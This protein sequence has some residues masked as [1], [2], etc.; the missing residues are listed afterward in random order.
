MTKA[1]IWLM[2]LGGVLALAAAEIPAA[3]PKTEKDFPQ[4]ASLWIKADTAVKSDFRK[5]RVEDSFSGTILRKL[6]KQ[7]E[8]GEF[9]AEYEFDVA[10]GGQYT[11]FAAL[12]AQKRPHASPVEFRF[13][14]GDWREV[15]N[16]P[17]SPAWGISNAI[18]WSS[19]GTV[20]LTAGKH[21]LALRI[22]KRAQLGS[23]SFM[24][25]GIVAFQNGVWKSAQITPPS[26]PATAMAGRKLELSYTQ[27]G[28]A[29]PALLRL[30]YAG[31]TVTQLTVLSRPGD[32]ANVLTLPDFLSSGQYQG[33]LVPADEPTH[34]FFALPVTIPAAAS[35]AARPAQLTAAVFEGGQYHLTFAG[36]RTS[37]VL[38]MFFTG[39]KL[40]FIQKL[41]RSTGTLPAELTQKLAGR[42][43][44]IRFQP[45][46]ADNDNF[47][48]EK[49]R[50]DGKAQSLPKPINYG[51]FT[52]RD[53]ITHVW[54][55]NHDF[56][57]IFDGVRYFP[58]GGM[59]CS[60]TLFSRSTD[61]AQI[62]VNLQKDLSTIRAIKAGGLDDV[63]LNLATQA[64]LWVRQAFVDMLQNEGIYYGYQLN[65][66]GG[67]QIPSF[68]ITRDRDDAPAN[69]RGLTR[70]TYANGKITARFPKEQKLL[71][72]LLVD[73]ATPQTS[74]RF[75][76]FADREGKDTRHGIIDLETQQDFGKLREISFAAQLALPD[77]TQVILIPLIEANMHHG[78]LWDETEMAELK[79]SLA[80]VG[81][82]NWGSNLRFWIEPIR[83]ET[84]MVNATENLR[85]Y[86]PAINRAFAAYLRERYQTLTKL[87]TAWGLA[88]NSF[89]QAARLIPLRLKDNVYYLDPEDGQTFAGSE[90]TTLAWIDYQ[91]MIRITYA[92]LADQVAMYLK[93]MVNVPVIFKSVGVIGEKLSVS[94]QYLGYDGVGFET[95]LNQGIPGETGGGASRAEAEASSHTMWKV[96]T[97]VGHSAAVGNGETKFFKDEAEIRGMADA[98]SRLGVRGFYF[99]GF[100]LKPGNLWL[101]HNYHDFPEGL[102]WAS[103]IDRESNAR[104][105]VAATPANYVFPGGF[106]W[107]WWTTRYHAVNDHEQNLIP[108]SA[109]LGKES[110]IYYSST[111][112]LPEQFNAVIINCPYPPFSRYHAADIEQAIRSGQTVY[113][114][115][116]RTD[117]GAIPALDA[118]FT[119][120]I[121]A[122]DDDSQAQVLNALPGCKILAAQNGKVWALAKDNLIIVSRTPVAKP[123]NSA[124][125]FLQYLTMF[126][127]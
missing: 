34:P 9:T 5:E 20:E 6:D 94:N 83:N 61:P 62:A 43:F 55:M 36:N 85:Q 27:S 60:D 19:L 75:F 127:R 39:G 4:K 117:L 77:Q 93:S 98:L 124:D 30:T 71:G 21:K 22:T 3:T 58:T 69:Y 88:V 97:E 108:Q 109:R 86:T 99:F 65:G 82:I 106:T 90:K 118:F 56:E 48:T 18:C 63:Y 113:Y 73:P 81:K 102:A 49:A 91:E 72:V 13:D 105:Q 57:Y 15:A 42:D 51:F 122:F 68:F 10:E 115:G 67:A 84:D 50:F 47:I 33:E 96:G 31:E 8:T 119:P 1:M 64:P 125:D 32:N 92:Q 79:N 116:Q 110:K 114:V 126:A 80:W 23:W 24:C 70:G 103:R 40:Y 46:P 66:G 121:I 101:N 89:D 38:A 107:W 100:D 112:V 95:Y 87:Q 76:N 25:D 28:P 44:S 26:T 12:I 7:P 17:G 35:R 111:N 54:Y 123:K 45:L 120:E 11:F 29:F 104:N 16:N 78:N 37:P 41:D 53:Q 74:A 2:T 59:W 14:D 52:D